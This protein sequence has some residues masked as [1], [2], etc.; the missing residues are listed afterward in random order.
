M[1]ITG[2][3]LV[4]QRDGAVLEF[5]RCVSLGV[6][7][8]DLLEL[9]RALVGE[10][11]H[12]PA[13]QEQDVARL[14]EVPRDAAAILG[15]PERVVDEAGELAEFGQPLSEGRVVQAALL[16]RA[17]S[18][19]RPRT[20][21]WQV[22]ALVEA[23]PISVPARIGRARSDSRAMELSATLTIDRIVLARSRQ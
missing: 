12:P 2:T 19:R 3:G 10:G 13:P 9:Q 6:D 4:D 14:G 21:S 17:S 7:V 5:A 18:A 15:Q 22:K 8:A 23:T 11:I 1:T 20:R 16:P